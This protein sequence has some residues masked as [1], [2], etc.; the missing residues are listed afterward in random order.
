MVIEYSCGDDENNII[1]DSNFLNNTNLGLVIKYVGVNNAIN[2][3]HRFI[4]NDKAT[5]Y[6]RESNYNNNLN[7]LGRNN[8][9]GK[10]I[11]FN[12]TDDPSTNAQYTLVNWSITT[13][14]TD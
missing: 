5:I 3:N 7:W 10:I 13:L 4:D 2:F 12:S 8:I 9:T 1:R 11:G 14:S 6:L